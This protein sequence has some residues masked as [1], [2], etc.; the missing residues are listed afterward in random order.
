MT[1]VPPCWR[2]RALRIR[3][4][5]LDDRLLLLRYGAR[6]IANESPV[7]LSL[8]SISHRRQSGQ[9]KSNSA[10]LSR[11]GSASLRRTCMN[12]SRTR[13]RSRTTARGTSATRPPSRTASPCSSRCRWKSGRSPTATA[14][15]APRT[16][17]QPG[18]IEPAANKHR[19]MWFRRVRWLL[20]YAGLTSGFDNRPT[21]QR[22]ST[23]AIS[24]IPQR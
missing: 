12:S 18:R 3:P 9:R 15:C 4:A 21:R 10:A 22:T 24:T 2:C 8:V 5:P 6:G 17:T 14:G 19:N 7:L 11:G 13:S 20:P 23:T 16:L 1:G